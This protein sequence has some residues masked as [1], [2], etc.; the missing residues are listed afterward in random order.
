[1]LKLLDL[2]SIGKDNKVIS[3]RDLEEG[4]K[5]ECGNIK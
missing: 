5:E 3:L 1:M 2:N 4:L